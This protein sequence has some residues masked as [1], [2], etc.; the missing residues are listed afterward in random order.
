MLD[1]TSFI[2]QFESSRNMLLH[3]ALRI[4]RSPEDAEDCVQSAFI[5]AWRNRENFRG[6]C[7]LSTWFTTIVTRQALELI[8]RNKSRCK[9]AH[10]E[11]PVEDKEIAS[12][13][14][15]AFRLAAGRELLAR[16]RKTLE[17]S[18]KGTLSVL[19]QHYYG[20]GPVE[21]SRLFGVDESTMKARCHKGRLRLRE[22]LS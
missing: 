6:D 11:L 7:A 9:M 18:P 8:R 12:E 14:P 5:C 15:C 20:Y 4:L 13:A 19:L 3:T 22:V 2:N 1:E 16:V 17:T 10:V 21:L